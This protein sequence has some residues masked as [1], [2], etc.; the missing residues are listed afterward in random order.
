M[1]LYVH[2]CLNTWAVWESVK[3]ESYKYTYYIKINLYF[4]KDMMAYIRYMIAGGLALCECPFYEEDTFCFCLYVWY[5]FDFI[6][7]A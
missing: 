7:D 2:V 5:V 6:K 4:C 1:F 3:A